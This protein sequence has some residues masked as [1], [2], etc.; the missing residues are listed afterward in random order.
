MPSFRPLFQ[1]EAAPKKSVDQMIQETRQQLFQAENKCRIN[2][3]REL[4]FGRENARKGK[5]DAGNYSRIG[6]AYYTLNIVKAAQDRVM[7]I[8][9]TRDLITAIDS[10]TNAVGMIDTLDRKKGKLDADSLVKSFKKY[11]KNSGGRD[12]GGLTE[13]LEKL[14]GLNP[15]ETNSIPVSSMV[16]NEVIDQLI[17]GTRK[18]DECVREEAGFTVSPNDIM[19]AVQEASTGQAVEGQ[20]NGKQSAMAEIDDLISS[21]KDL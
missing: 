14:S 8:Q 17:S 13:A 15:E 6:I 11:L 7:G 5:K 18:V 16:S 1:R 2:L 9:S 10:T 3:E 20:S 19:T 21:L 4:L 12:D